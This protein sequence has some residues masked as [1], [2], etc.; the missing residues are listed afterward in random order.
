METLKSS[1][2]PTEQQ[3]K[4][5]LED[6]H[7]FLK[8]GKRMYKEVSVFLRKANKLMLEAK[9]DQRKQE[10]F[11]SKIAYTNEN[12]EETLCN[13]LL[14]I[15]QCEFLKAWYPAQQGQKEQYVVGKYQESKK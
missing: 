8:Q 5:F 1:H 7:D 11:L 3:M 4:Q 10:D 13:V 9:K 12:V 6:T 14:A 2:L 15:R